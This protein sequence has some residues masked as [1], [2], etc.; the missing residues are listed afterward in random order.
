MEGQALRGRGRRRRGSAK[1][2]SARRKQAK[3]GPQSDLAEAILAAGSNALRLHDKQQGPPATESL[4]PP[5]HRL[6]D[7]SHV[8]EPASEIF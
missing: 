4:G 7:S 5:A 6:P 2:A 8:N 3:K 1:A